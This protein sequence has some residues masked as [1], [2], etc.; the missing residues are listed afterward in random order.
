MPRLKF[1][2]R[3]SICLIY[4]VSSLQ[5]AGTVYSD[6]FL[7]DFETGYDGWTR[8]GQEAA[9][10]SSTVAHAGTHSL[11]FIGAQFNGDLAYH[12]ISIP[13]NTDFLALEAWVYTTRTDSHNAVVYF[14]GANCGTVA[15]GVGFRADG[16]VS[17]RV[18]DNETRLPMKYKKDEWQ[19][20]R[21]VLD[22][23]QGHFSGSLN[24]VPLG[25]E[26]AAAFVSPQTICIGTNNNI[27]SGTT[28]GTTVYFDDVRVQSS[29]DGRLNYV[30]LGDSFSSG[31]GA[32]DYAI[33]TNFDGDTDDPGEDTDICIHSP[34][35][36]TYCDL[37]Y[38]MC[39]RSRSAYP[40]KSLRLAE[41]V[42]DE[43]GACSGAKTKNLDMMGQ[44]YDYPDNASQF[45]R[46]DL[47]S[48]T[49]LVTVSI[50]GNDAL[51]KRI[52]VHCLALSPLVDC[53][54]TDFWDTNPFGQSLAEFMPNLIDLKVRSDARRVFDTLRAAAPNARI[55]VLGYPRLFEDGS[56]CVL[57]LSSGEAVWLNSVAML[58]NRTLECEAF[59]AGLEF[60]SVDS[61]FENHR[62]CSDD[63]WIQRPFRP[64]SWVHWLHPTFEGQTRGYRQSL[65]AQLGLTPA[66]VSCSSPSAAIF[67]DQM[68]GDVQLPSMGNLSIRLPIDHCSDTSLTPGLL[69]SLSSSGF[70]ASAE[71]SL[72][73]IADSEYSLVTV[74]AS[75]EGAIEASV[76]L[77]SFAPGAFTTLLARGLDSSGGQRAAIA[78]GHTG[79][80][81]AVDGDEDGVPDACDNCPLTFNSGQEDDDFDQIGDA[82]DVCPSDRFNDLDGDSLCASEDPCP[83][84]ATN[85]SDADQICAPADNCPENFNPSQADSDLDGIG[86]SCDYCS[87]PDPLCLFGDR[88]ETGDTTRWSNVV[89]GIPI[90]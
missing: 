60:L 7:E 10:T 74:T 3:F 47:S 80:S 88:F 76:E 29:V 41:V 13:E 56:D 28:G 14:T 24:G 55:I 89:D 42:A 23:D 25:G 86:D 19:L 8:Y 83:L 58:L 37:A 59:D 85:D 27:G 39:H 20:L 6:V 87:G 18:L 65:E 57:G 53:Q 26:F 54:N 73:L 50:G 72:T 21:L 71:V 52:I 38:N 81:L 61:A 22:L 36:P 16:W 1:L 40:V 69:V 90:S 68:A 82:C 34:S 5:A 63:E 2:L 4:A 79:E 9:S 46:V 35:P 45:G 84:D 67:R 64:T 51:F 44:G 11:K 48:D 31:E 62:L 43:F 30:A 70:A 78:Y 12:P 49:D 66:P 15:A 17:A 32:L 75:A 33:D 77:P